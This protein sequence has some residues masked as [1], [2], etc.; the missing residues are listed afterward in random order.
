MMKYPFLCRY[1]GKV[2][3]ARTLSMPSIHLTFAI[4]V[5]ALTLTLSPSPSHPHPHP[6]T[7][8]TYPNSYP[9]P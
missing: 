8:T 3:C 4:L 7:L 1:K 6:L 9:K 2:H 5:V